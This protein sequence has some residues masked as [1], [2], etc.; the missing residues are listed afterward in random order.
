[1][2]VTQKTYEDKF[3]SGGL[4]GS[5]ALDIRV[6]T[7]RPT[8]SRQNGRRS[9]E[10]MQNSGGSGSKYQPS[11]DSIAAKYSSKNNLGNQSEI[12]AGVNYR[13]LP[14]PTQQTDSRRDTN[15][16]EGFQ[17]AASS[18]AR[19]VSIK[20]NLPGYSAQRF[21]PPRQ[22]KELSKPEPSSSD[23]LDSIFQGLRSKRESGEYDDDNLDLRLLG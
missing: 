18:G 15:G 14:N 1:V 3:E 11:R 6:S 20:P 19:W 17:T 13:P 23:S 7:G 12:I 21:A 5:S 22:E 16:R 2:V 4:G 9:E 10:E 8:D